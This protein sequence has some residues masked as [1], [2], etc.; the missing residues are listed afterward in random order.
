MFQ[1]LDYP[2]LYLKIMLSI[3]IVS[4][5]I[6]AVI[7]CP[8]AAFAR[9]GGAF[10]KK[11]GTLFLWNVAIISTTGALSLLDP[12]FLSVYWSEESDLKGFGQ[13]FQSAKLPNLF[14]LFIMIMFSYSAFS[15]ARIWP[16]LR[17]SVDQRIASSRFDW[18]ITLAM[19]LIS[20]V[21][22]GIGIEDLI[23]HDAF[24]ATFIGGP[25]IML[26]FVAFDI[27]TFVK[28]P[29]VSRYKWWML[30]VI[31]IMYVWAGLIQGFWL[32]VRAHILPPEWQEFPPHSGTLLWVLL[33]GGAIWL[34]HTRYLKKKPVKAVI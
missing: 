4:A 8:A 1:E 18:V 14:F 20:L 10:H 15:A 7:L 23:E 9:K 32:R 34:Y 21:F 11:I 22:L 30:H 28:K 3:H 6:G 33:A 29:P 25:S 16:R 24:A 19:G 2:T 12:S 27:Y 5:L 17:E 31:K 26:G 13:I